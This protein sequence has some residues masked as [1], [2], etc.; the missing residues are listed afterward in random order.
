MIVPIINLITDPPS[1]K[2]IAEKFRGLESG[3][4]FR[5]SGIG[6]GIKNC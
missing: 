3:P 6:K 5:V 4:G 1:H 2:A